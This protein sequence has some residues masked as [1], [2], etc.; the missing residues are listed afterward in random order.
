MVKVHSVQKEERLDG[1]KHKTF[2]KQKVKW[3]M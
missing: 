3:L 2:R 1:Q